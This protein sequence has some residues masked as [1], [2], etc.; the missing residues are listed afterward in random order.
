ME[1]LI[2]EIKPYALTALSVSLLV[3]STYSSTLMHGSAFLLLVAAS[4]IIKARWMNRGLIR[5]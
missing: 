2:Y 1:K 4:T 3:S 5:S